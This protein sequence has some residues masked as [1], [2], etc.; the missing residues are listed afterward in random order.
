MRQSTDLF[1]NVVMIFKYWTCWIE[2]SRVCFQNYAAKICL[3]EN[4]NIHWTRKLASY[5][6]STCSAKRKEGF[7]SQ[8]VSMF[9]YLYMS[10]GPSW[11]CSSVSKW[12][13]RNISL[14]NILNCRLQGPNYETT[15]WSKQS[16]HQLI[17]A[18]KN[19]PTV[20]MS[21]VYH[22]YQE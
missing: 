11:A 21:S 13:A 15:L 16:L 8:T 14:W 1:S 6:S 3:C 4:V 20:I 7:V 22:L 10:A 2:S 19:F 9:A 17:H 5:V 12:K 18:M